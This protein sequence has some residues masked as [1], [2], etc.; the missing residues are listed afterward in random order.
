MSLVGR[1]VLIRSSPAG[2]NTVE[3]S[4]VHA[5][6]DVSIFPELVNFQLFC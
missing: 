4:V 2:G 1:P 6:E 3:S 5:S